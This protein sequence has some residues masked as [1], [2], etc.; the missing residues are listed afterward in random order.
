MRSVVATFFIQLRC[1]LGRRKIKKPV[2]RGEEQEQSAR[3]HERVHP[4]N[5]CNISPS[6]C[7]SYLFERAC[8]TLQDAQPTCHL[9]NSL[10]PF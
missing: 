9:H 2:L 5:A 3:G 4:G 7:V 8:L 10:E 6:L 1:R